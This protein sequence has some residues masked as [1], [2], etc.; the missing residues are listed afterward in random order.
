MF[1]RTT[2]L[3]D[4]FQSYL[5]IYVVIA[6][7]FH[8]KLLSCVIIGEVLSQKGALQI[9]CIPVDALISYLC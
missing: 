3:A 1:I 8:Q 2:V 4:T 6:L 9:I 7:I 5:G